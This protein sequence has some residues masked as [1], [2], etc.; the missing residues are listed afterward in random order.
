VM[1]WQYFL[2]SYFSFSIIVFFFNLKSESI[3]RPWF[4][5]H[6]SWMIGPGSLVWPRDS[7]VLV[8]ILG[9]KHWDVIM[10]FPQKYCRPS[11]ISRENY[12]GDVD[13]KVEILLERSIGISSYC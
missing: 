13:A 7:G 5:T 8:S 2:E 6:E 3:I 4:V 10:I 9:S 12:N 1:N 11:N